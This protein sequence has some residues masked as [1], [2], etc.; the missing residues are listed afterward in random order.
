[1]DRL[2]GTGIVTH[3][4][5]I[6][7]PAAAGAPP[8]VIDR[9][10]L[11]VGGAALAGLALVGRT[12]PL[13]SQRVSSGAASTGA[14][15]AASFAPHVGTLFGV[16]AREVGAIS[17][18]LIEVAPIQG[19]PSEPTLLS[20]SAYALILEGPAESPLPAAD[21]HLRHAV[22]DLPPLHVSPVGLTSR[23]QDYQIIVDTRTFESGPAPR[24]A[25]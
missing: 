13:I 19:H 5:A 9:R 3:V 10:R 21:Y 7:S 15:S 11:L 6:P 23:V 8:V 14:L 24:K 12:V 20:G 18:R 4:Q 17:L 22:L 1:M 16:R 25:D 2:A